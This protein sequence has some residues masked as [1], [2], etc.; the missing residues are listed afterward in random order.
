MTPPLSRYRSRVVPAAALSQADT[1]AWIALLAA[2]HPRGNAFLSAGFAAAAARVIPGV[3][4]CLIE[5]GAGLAAVLACQDAPGTGRMLRAAQRVGEEMNDSFGLVARP[6][7]RTTPSALLRL[8]GLHHLYFTHLPETQAAFGLSGEKPV[9]GLRIDLSGGGDAY[10]AALNAADRKFTSDTE[11]RLRKAQD[12]LGPMRFTLDA[13][14]PAALLDALLDHKRAQYLRTGKGDWLAA[15]GR[16]GLLRELAQARGAPDC[17]AQ[18]SVLHFGDTWAAMHFGLRSRETLH[19]WI[20]VY[21]PALNAYAPGRLLLREI[22]RQ[23][24]AAGITLIDRG[25]GESA[26]KRDF[27]SLPRTY[28]SG[29]WYR[30]TPAGLAYRFWQSARWRLG[31]GG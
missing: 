31:R 27:A 15:P 19:Y 23:G 3:K 21:N 5:D 16:G 29:V 18:M 2:Q 11:R 1:D 22:I 14:D 9:T 26:A 6:D 17:R 24:P 12:D 4:A 25:V 13:E 10:W 20:P 28:L 7:F 8:A 30:P